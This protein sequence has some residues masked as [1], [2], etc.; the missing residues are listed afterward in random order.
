MINLHNKDCMEA[1]KEFKDNQFDLAIV[2]PPYGIGISGQKEVKKGKKSDRKFH[3]EKEWDNEIPSKEYFTQLQRVSNNQIIWGANYFVEHLTKGSKG[4]IVWDKKQYGLTMSDCELAYSSFQKPTRV[5]LQ[6]RVILQQEG[7]TIHPTQK[8]I[9]LYEFLLMNYAK[10]GD[11]ILD[12]HLGSGSI[13]I[14]CNN[15]G[16]DLEGYELDKEYFEAA[17]KRLK[18]HQQQIRMFK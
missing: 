6:N 15:L 4:W 9:K 16:F 11:K 13:A 10:E 2:D 7:N 3:K 17:N 5:F 18:Q 14:A 1:L 12:T 8:P